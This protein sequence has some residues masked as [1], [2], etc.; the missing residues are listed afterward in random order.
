VASVSWLT[1]CASIGPPEPPA[2]ELPKPPTDL[3][4]VRKGD[5]VTLTWTVPER[6]MDRQSVRYLGKTHICRSVESPLKLC[7]KPVGEAAPEDFKNEESK[8]IPAR[9]HTGKFTDTLSSA[10]EQEHAAEFASYAVEVMNSAGRAAGISN[11]A[12]V[13]LVP[14]LPPF[15]DFVAQ[16]V[17]QGVM[18]SWKCPENFGAKSD[19]KYLFRIYRR[20]ESGSELRIRDEESTECA[21][22]SPMGKKLVGSFL[23]R[24]FEWESTYFYH[25]AVV[26]V[27]QAGGKA[28]VE[29]E[30]DDTPEVKVFAHDIFPPA[31]PSG[32]QAVFSGPGQ[33]AFIDLIWSPVSD[34][35][36]AGYN[37]YR[38]EKDGAMVK[39]NAELVKTPAYRDKQV[40]AGRTYFYSVSAVDERGNESGRSEETSERV[41]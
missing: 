9:K 15:G 11:Q 37:L 7:G 35:D 24:S 3:R 6:T 1:S 23:D 4:A 8:K 22:R 29:V 25:G 16:P 27:L 12:R 20:P 30:G 10:F 39:L 32:V 41:P 13:A 38:H 31:I 34:A 17:A 19:V 26:S 33:E 18:I 36:L 5:R 2:L 40:A 21:N 14:T 28:P